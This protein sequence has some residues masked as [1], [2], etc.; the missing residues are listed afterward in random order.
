MSILDFVDL[1]DDFDDDDDDVNFDCDN[2]DDD[3]SLKLFLKYLLLN[4]VLYGEQY[5]NTLN[6]N[7]IV[8]RSQDF[9][10]NQSLL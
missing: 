1:S 5:D 9:N 3:K 10:I 8:K 7:N 2:V 6:T 4:G